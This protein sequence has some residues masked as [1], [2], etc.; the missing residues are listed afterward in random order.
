MV[1]HVIQRG[2]GNKI[3]TTLS[4]GRILEKSDSQDNICPFCRPSIQSLYDTITRMTIRIIIPMWLT[5]NNTV[6]TQLCSTQTS[7][8]GSSILIS[9]ILRSSCCVSSFGFMDVPAM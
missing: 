8:I 4:S 2:N 5:R 1:F 7:T 3:K 6:V 9:I